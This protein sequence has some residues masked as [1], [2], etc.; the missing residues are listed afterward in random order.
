MVVSDA[1]SSRYQAKL[2]QPILD[3]NLVSDELRDLVEEY[4][5][6]LLPNLEVQTLQRAPTQA[7]VRISVV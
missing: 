6:W 1:T 5:P 7:D 4:W 2:G 3:T